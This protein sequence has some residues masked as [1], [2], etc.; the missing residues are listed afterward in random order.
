MAEREQGGEGFVEGK[1]RAGADGETA[2]AVSCCIGA[3]R[4]QSL[5]LAPRVFDGVRLNLHGYALSLPESPVGSVIEEFAIWRTKAH[6]P[7]KYL[8]G[9]RRRS[10]EG[11]SAG[12][13]ELGD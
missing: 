13:L 10:G 4:A 6:W 11:V 1:A 2:K 12:E 9:A 8:D 7:Q 5:R 3:G